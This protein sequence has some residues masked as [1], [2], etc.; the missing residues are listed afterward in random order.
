M[1]ERISYLTKLIS[2]FLLFETI[3]NSIKI[4]AYNDQYYRL[5]SYGLVFIIPAAVLWIISLKI[6]TKKQWQVCSYLILAYGII[7]SLM[8]GMG[9][10][11][12][13]TFF[14]FSIHTDY[15][16]N[17][18]M[19][20][21]FILLL[22]IAVKTVFVDTIGIQA[23]NLMAVNLFIIGLYFVLIKLPENPKKINIEMEDQ[24]KQIVDYL[25]AGLTIKEISDQVYINPTTINKRISRLKTQLNCKT[26]Y[27]LFM[28]IGRD[29]KELDK[30]TYP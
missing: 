19:I 1:V 16:K 14:I 21:V 23:I 28:K 5:I 24:T 27:Q 20:K 7:Y 8:P 3:I 13:A 30:P 26:N 11:S 17:K 10:F 9:N 29:K 25:D 15:S 2:S 22:C 12:G 4:I 6:S 18:A